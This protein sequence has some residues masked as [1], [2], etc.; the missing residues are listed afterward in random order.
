MKS[1]SHVHVCV[2]I[3]VSCSACFVSAFTDG[4]YGIIGIANNDDNETWNINLNWNYAKC[5]KI[6][7]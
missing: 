1:S 3:R 2:F 5:H 4:M 6:M 7:F